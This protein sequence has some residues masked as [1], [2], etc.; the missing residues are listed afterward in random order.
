MT[1][2]VTVSSFKPEVLDCLS[3]SC[4]PSGSTYVGKGTV[5]MTDGILNKHVSYLLEKTVSR[6]FQ[7]S[8]FLLHKTN[9]LV[10]YFYKYEQFEPLYRLWC[11]YY[12]SLLN[13]SGTVDDRLLKA[14]YHGCLF[15]VSD[16]SNPS[17]IGLNG[18]V[19]KETRHTFQIIT[20]KN[21]LLTIPKEGTSF[22]F[23]F[24]GKIFTL[25]ADAFRFVHQTFYYYI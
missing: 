12:G 9:L 23:V 3:R 19:V 1:V 7:Y 18:I 10:Y 13:L 11:D 24:A 4:I 25:F 5:K 15:L 17:Q 14:D 21:K 22:Q 8:L 2:S 20:R 6:E 16:A